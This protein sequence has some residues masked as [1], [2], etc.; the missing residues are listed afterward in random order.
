MKHYGTDDLATVLTS[1]GYIPNSLWLYG[2][3]ESSL[4]LWNTLHKIISL[5]G[6]SYMERTM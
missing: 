2:Y 6:I 1:S 5:G 4:S 3:K